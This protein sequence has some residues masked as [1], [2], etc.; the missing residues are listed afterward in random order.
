VSVFNNCGTVLSKAE[1]G[2][3][4][5]K[6]LVE[7]I[8]LINEHNKEQT[9]FHLDTNAEHD[10]LKGYNATIIIPNNLTRNDRQ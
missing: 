4:G 3:T 1:K 9:S 2:G 7:T 6:V 10:G 8:R 5:L